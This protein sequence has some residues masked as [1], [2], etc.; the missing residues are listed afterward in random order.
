M[1]DGH[2]LKCLP[3]APSHYD[4][5]GESRDDDVAAALYIIGELF[6]GDDTSRPVGGIT[7]RDS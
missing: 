7:S 1:M 3:S 2:A 4:F 6:V 5:L